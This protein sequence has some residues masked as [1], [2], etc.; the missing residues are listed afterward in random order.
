M[1]RKGDHSSLLHFIRHYNLKFSFVG[2]RKGGKER[3]GEKKLYVRRRGRRNSLFSAEFLPFF[4]NPL[5]F[6]IVCHRRK[7]GGEGRG[8][9]SLEGG[10]RDRKADLT[11]L[12]LIQLAA[13]SS[14]SPADTKHLRRKKRKRG[15]EGKEG[16]SVS[17]FNTFIPLTISG[18]P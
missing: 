15:K 4:Q 16:M 17:C 6:S 1:P 12:P 10:E 13:I 9:N 7:G 2:L 18:D 3:R 5:Y 14:I 8:K 11:C